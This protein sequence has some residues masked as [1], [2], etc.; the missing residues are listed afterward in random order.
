MWKVTLRGL[1]AHKL[2]FALTAL[3]IVLGVG[4][5][6][7]TF[8]LTDTINRT[9]EE[10][11]RQTTKGVDVAVR[12]KT[13]FAGQGGEQRAPMPA[14]VL[15][16]VRSEVPGVEAVQGNVVG[17]AQFIDKTGKP[18]T[19]VGAPSIGSSVSVVPQLQAGATVRDGSRPTGPGQVA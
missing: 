15:D 13:T 5:V 2:R 16:R 3:A 8:V 1:T 6:A 7:G 19:T 11:F 14:S 18:V 4:F 17:Y 9:F 10:L 12:T